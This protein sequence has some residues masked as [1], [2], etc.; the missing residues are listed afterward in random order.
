MRLAATVVFLSVVT[1]RASEQMRSAD[2]METGSW[3]VS[4]SGSQG[5]H[6]GLQFHVGGTDLIQIPL[7]GGATAQVFGCGHGCRV[8]WKA[9]YRSAEAELAARNRIELFPPLGNR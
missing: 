7:S 9:S 3:A 2:S 5:R 4:F 1:A 6:E 8:R